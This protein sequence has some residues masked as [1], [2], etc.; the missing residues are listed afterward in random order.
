MRTKKCNQCG[1]VKNLKCFSA[2]KRNKT[3]CRQPKCK[4]CNRKYYQRN[5]ERVKQRVKEHYQ[6]NNEEILVRRAELRK[7]PEAKK[8]KTEADVRYY[9]ENKT[10]VRQKQKE[11]VNSNREHLRAYQSWWRH[12]REAWL[13]NNGNNTLTVEEVK[14]IFA[15]HP[16]CEYCETTENLTLDHIIPVSRGGQNCIDNI[17]VAC[18]QCNCSKNN[19]LLL[20]WEGRVLET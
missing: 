12:N 1:E 6:N 17:T 11:W 7:R 2:N 4:D 14:K 19:K 10:K 18:H 9:R 3:D 5:R 8:K 15:I 13:Q 20:E 16:Y